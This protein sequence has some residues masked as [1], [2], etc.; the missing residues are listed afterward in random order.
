MRIKQKLVVAFLITTLVPIAL[1]ASYM[2]SQSRTLAEQ[3]FAELSGKEVAK[4]DDAFTAFFDEIAANV[5]FLA[6]SPV[7]KQA[8]GSLSTY[9]DKQARQMTPDRNGPVEQEIYAL[10]ERFGETHPGFAYVYMGTA[11][12]GYV[13]WPKG[14]SGDNYDPRKRPWFQ[15]ALETPGKLAMTGAYYWATDDQTLYG[16]VKSFDT[17]ERKNYGVMAMDVSL[18]ALTEMA[19]DAELGERGYMML[20]ED[21]GTV[22]VDAANPEHNFKKL[23][24]LEGDA[25]KTLSNTDGGQIRISL[26]GETYE[27]TVHRS[28]GLGWKMIALMPQSEIMAP[29]I[30][31]I[32]TTLGITAVAVLAVLLLAFWIAGMLVKPILL[33]SGGLREIAEGGG[34]LTRRLSVSSR[35]EAGQLAQW[36]NEFLESIQQLVARINGTAQQFKAASEEGRSSALSVEKASHHQF[37]EVEAMVAAVNEMSA[38]ANEVA[39]NCAMTAEAAADGQSVSENGKQVVAETEQSVRAL[40]GQVSQSVG[41]IRELEAETA[42]INTILGVI[43]GIAEQTNLLALNAAIEAARAGDQGRGF[44]VVADEVRSLAQRTQESTEEIDTLLERLNSRTHRVVEN[45]DASQTQSERAVERVAQ[46]R[47]AFESI[48]AS[49]DRISDMTSQIAGAAEEQHQVSEGINANIEAI[50]GAANEVNEVSSLVAQN[51][52]H[53]AALAAELTG[54]V[55]QFKV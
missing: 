10:L 19:R 46:A 6:R 55:N 15:R 50:H 44:A 48:K 11:D 33:V 35:D 14:Q 28:P 18:N 43:R 41:Y 40:S 4:L 13:Q 34:D 49:I 38:T 47:E 52:E 27:A 25:Y 20:I 42:R 22:L 16:V 5:D 2:I 51:A 26:N 54:L 36:F 17:A 30:G 53:Q 1:L 45:M 21:T 24:E 32:W 3:R 29:A 9:M 7:L 37:S 39:R 31:I 23:R 12:G 8:D